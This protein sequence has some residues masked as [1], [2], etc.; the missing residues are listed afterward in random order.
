MPVR[1]VFFSAAGS[2]TKEFLGGQRWPQAL[3]PI[4]LPPTV[5][6]HPKFPPHLNLAPS[7]FLGGSWKHTHTSLPLLVSAET[8]SRLPLPHPDT[9]VHLR[10]FQENLYF[11]Q[12]RCLC[13]QKGKWKCI[14]EWSGFSRPSTISLL[15]SFVLHVFTSSYPDSISAM[16]RTIQSSSVTT[17]KVIRW[18][19]LSQSQAT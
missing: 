11:S 18:Q 3:T 13:M 4:C 8:H 12:N 17:F 15:S 7:A 1:A 5:T 14:A 16:N 2:S 6:L 9:Q 10:A 19:F